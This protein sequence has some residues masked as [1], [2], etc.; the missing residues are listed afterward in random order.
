[1]DQYFYGARDDIQEAGVQY[2]RKA[3]FQNSRLMRWALSIQQFK[4]VV[5]YIRGK[6]NVCAD[7]LSRMMDDSY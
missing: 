3:Q 2:L 1:M 5:K 7:Y 4:F 6:D